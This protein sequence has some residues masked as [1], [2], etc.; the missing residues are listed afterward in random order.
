MKDKVFE[1]SSR[2][3]FEYF[4]RKNS[5]NSH[6]FETYQDGT[7]R[8]DLSKSFEIRAPVLE[9]RIQIV[10]NLKVFWLSIVTKEHYTILAF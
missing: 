6:V 4:K 9:I 2:L 7:E 10:F 3:N 1:I 8:D 5:L